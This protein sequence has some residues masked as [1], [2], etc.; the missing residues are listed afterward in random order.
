MTNSFRAIKAPAEAQGGLAASLV[1]S[2]PLL[3]D[4]LPV[5]FVLDFKTQSTYEVVLTSSFG[6]PNYVC[7]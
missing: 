3:R 5:F 6:K 7:E 1:S 2:L 4:W